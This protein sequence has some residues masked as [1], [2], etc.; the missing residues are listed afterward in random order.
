VNLDFLSPIEASDLRR[1]SIPLSD[2][3]LT[4]RSTDGGTH[5]VRFYADISGEWAHGSSTALINWKSESIS[6]SLDGSGTGGALTA[7]E[8]TPSAPSV[9]AETNDYPDWGTAVLA[10]AT[11]SN[12]T[13]QSGPDT[14]VRAQFLNQNVLTNGNDTNQPRAINNNWPVF[15]FCLD[16]GNVTA[17]ASA[18]FSLTLGHA[19]N[20]AVSY[21]GANVAPLWASYWST[22]QAMLAFQY[23][24][25]AAEH[26]RSSAFDAQLTDAATR[27]G[28]AHYAGLV[29][30]ALRQHGAGGS[31]DEPLAHAQGDQQR[32]QRLHGGCGLSRLSGHAVHEPDPGPAPDRTH[33]CLRGIRPLAAALRR[34]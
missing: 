1:L 25:M 20:P 28:G 32:W 10:T 9:L 17:T 34:A 23:N 26:T 13:T 30:L 8:I 27:V 29:D 14:T 3:L 21:L 16:A 6:R 19:R 18:P 31:L 11:A 2:I 33:D 5:A 22:Y 24:D 12:L 4:A 15:A 7:W